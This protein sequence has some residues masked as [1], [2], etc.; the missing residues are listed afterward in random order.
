MFNT[1][2]LDALAVSRINLAQPLQY[3][4]PRSTVYENIS[5][6]DASFSENIIRH[7]YSDRSVN[8]QSI[9]LIQLETATVHAR[10]DFTVSVDTASILEQQPPWYGP[11]T[12]NI[13]ASP[14]PVEEVAQDAVIIAR[15]GFWTW[16]HW[17]GELLPKLVLTER[18]F[19]G[20]FHYVVPDTGDFPQWRNFRDSIEAYGVSR[21][22]LILIKPEIALKLRRPWAVTPVW[23]DRVMHPD[24]AEAMRSSL[25]GSPRRLGRKIALF[26]QA[27]SARTLVNWDQIATMLVARGYEIIDIA[28]LPFATQVEAFREATAVFSTLGSGLTGLIYSPIGVRVL[29]VAPSLFGDW[30]FYALLAGRQGLYADVRGPIVTP[31]P[32]IPHRGAFRVDPDRVLLGLHAIGA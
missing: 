17:L 24:A 27:D 10:A 6:F 30:F 26:R 3:I 22:R 15:Y 19:P 16:G 11:T 4:V 5:E 32:A 28:A 9:D 20:R 29:S 25:S 7:V 31:D 8:V 1:F 13:M 2:P 23:S 21:S 14:G 18:A 12:E